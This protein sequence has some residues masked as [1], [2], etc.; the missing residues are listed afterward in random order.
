MIGGMKRLQVRAGA[1]AAL[2]GAIREFTALVRAHEPG[3][4]S[5]ELFRDGAPGRYVILDRYRDG[6]ALAAHNGSP[7]GA[8]WF[9][10]VRALLERLDVSYFPAHDPGDTQYTAVALTRAPWEKAFRLAADIRLLPRWATRFC[11]GMREEG[12]VLIVRSPQ[13]DVRFRYEADVAAR[14]IWHCA[15]T[16]S[17]ELRMPM[18][19]LPH[20]PGSLLLFTIQRPTSGSEAA[21]HEQIEWVDQEMGQLREL[22]EA[23]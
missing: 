21:F 2:E 15:D 4:L 17:G 11:Q 23:P 10:R 22:V 9:P 8:I 13:G 6:E 7:H 18:R 5:F 16:G 3:T 20:G 14:V 1:E 19:V 12:V